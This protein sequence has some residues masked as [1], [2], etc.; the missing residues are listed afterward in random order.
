MDGDSTP[1]YRILA[2]PREKNPRMPVP[3]DA[4]SS[5]LAASRL[6]PLRTPMP[7]SLQFQAQHLRQLTELS[8]APGTPKPL[9][10]LI[11]V[12]DEQLEA[13][14]V[15]IEAVRRQR[16]QVHDIAAARH[17]RRPRAAR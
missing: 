14:Q 12:T 8:T 2:P 10:F 15:A 6:T 16:Q 7:W 5:S 17:D 11:E 13:L 3:A 4:P 9:E 1:V